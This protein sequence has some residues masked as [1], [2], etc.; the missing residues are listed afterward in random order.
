MGIVSSSS[1]GGNPIV[2][3]AIF[4]A[5]CILLSIS[6]V[7]T[8]CEQNAS[9]Q[10]KRETLPGEPPA[11]QPPAQ[12]VLRMNLSMEPPTVDPAFAEDSTSATVIRATFDGLTRIGPDG[13]PEFAVANKMEVSPDRLTYTFYLRD[14]QWSNGEPVTAHDFEYAWKRVLDPRTA[15]IY[16]YQMYYLKN[17][18]K[19]NNGL[20]SADEVGVKAIDDKTLVVKLEHPTSYFPEL[21]AF[22][23]YYPVYQ[24]GIEANSRWAANADTHVG[25]GP[26]K[27]EQ[28]DHHAKLILAKNNHY[29]DKDAVNLDRVEFSMYADENTEL[30][31]F[32]KDELDWAGAPLSTL[33]MQAIPSL[34]ESEKIN[35]QTIAAIYMYKFNT[36]Q[37]PFNNAKIRKAFSYAINRQYIIDHIRQ[38]HQ[39]PAMGFVPPA[40]AVQ[41]EPYFVDNDTQTAQKL[42]QEGLK[43][44]GLDALPPITLTFNT[45]DSHKQLA[46]AV[47]QQWRNVFHIDVKLEDKE[48]TRFLEEQH[49]GFY[50]ISRSGWLGDFNDPIS[51]LGIFR[52]RSGGNND[53]GWE[54]ASYQ[55]LLKQSALEMD[56]QKRNQLLAQAEQILMDEMP[57]AP[58]F[59]YTNSWVKHDRVRGVFIDGMGNLE[60]KWGEIAQE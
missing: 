55:A 32:E 25:N 4:L 36:Q 6:T 42:L 41:T 33:P 51:F 29:W 52:D 46:E 34:T 31:L 54:N 30:F 17:G 21:T 20:A 5:M 38:G 53:T 50:Q 56:S 49:K 57:I 26:F 18:E 15:S 37:V 47:A 60:L 1:K 39:Q 44:L 48:W 45:S 9:S 2:R 14:T 40:M 27:I 7:I 8:G 35:T 13:S 11:K 19:F 28:W 59:Y 58:L 12:K 3:K 43:E 23:T 24:K 16:A 22:Y 10:A